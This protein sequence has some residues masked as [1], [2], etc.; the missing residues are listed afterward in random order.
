MS[1]HHLSRLHGLQTFQYAVFSTIAA[2]LLFS[3]CGGAPAAFSASYPDNDRS[4]IQLLIK[5]IQRA[6]EREIRS[7]AV[8]VTPG[9]SKLY[10]FDLKAQRVLW[11]RPTRTSITPVVA[12]D[13]VLTHE[14]SD[15]VGREVESGDSGFE[16]DDRNMT[17]VGADASEQLL[18]LT[19]TKGSS[20]FADSA[21][22]AIKSRSVIWKREF[23]GRVGSPAVI[24]DVVLVPWNHQNLSAL[25]AKSGDEFARIRLKDNVV[26]HA[27]VHANKLF[28]G[29]NRLIFEVTSSLS[30]GLTRKSPYFE[31]PE[32]SL[33]GDPLLLP[34]VYSPD[35]IQPPDSGRHRIALGWRPAV[36]SLPGKSRIELQDNNLYLLF[37]RFVVAF[38]PATYSVR[39]IYTHPTDIVG[40]AV[41]AGGVLFA[42][43]TGY[44]GFLS[45]TKGEKLWDATSGLTSSVITLRPDPVS[46]FS[47]TSESLRP[48][49]L[50][51]QLMVA[52]RDPDAR[53]VPVRVLVV[54][55]LAALD[56]PESTS[57]L[58]EICDNRD[59]TE[60][61]KRAACQALAKRKVGADQVLDT[62][63]RRA[64]YLDGTTSPPVGA[65][66][67]AAAEQ[68]EKRAVALLIGHLKDPQTPAGELPRL[69]SALKQL[70]D[71]SAVA[72]MTDFLRLY[73]ADAAE[74]QLI[75][76]LCESIDA[77]IALSGPACA[78]TLKEI[79]EDSMG[80]QA[81]REKAHAALQLLEQQ[82]RAAEQLEKAKQAE[83]QAEAE[84]AQE[85]ATAPK[86][87]M[88]KRLSQEVV[89][90]V[91]LPVRDQM[92]SCL[93]KSPDRVFSA[94][95]LIMV[96]NGETSLVSVMPA[97]LQRC[98]EPLVRSQKFPVTQLFGKENVAYTITLR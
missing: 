45:A 19:L 23:Q 65:L 9:P 33:P 28:A 68:G 25:N 5:R 38:E 79:A 24:G 36:V 39:W 46:Q 74:P 84:Q 62:L 78:E 22:Y 29:S 15:I 80:S 30:S 86:P 75:E 21:V 16:I 55:L 97:S 35:P 85:E 70:Q 47:V 77:L 14:G 71:H 26:G 66:A 37:Y 44:V 60:Q 63:K 12:G 76:A 91:L 61:V 94:R 73:H 72:P 27:F 50:R 90:E 53:L 40:A 13:Y 58:I 88:P 95:V 54:E 52:V 49:Q 56:D 42:D 64:N 48:D 20:S 93:R 10:A 11:Q 4:D 67:Q 89:R 43:T 41:Q 82:K 98:I 87:E 34:D 18:A 57:N 2:P 31:L 7:L 3:A 6:E 69:V 81:V 8:G 1:R 83:Q 32:R 92:K 17:L 59:A 96:D 51:G